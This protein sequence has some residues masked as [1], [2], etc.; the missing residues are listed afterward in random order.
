MVESVVTLTML[1]YPRTSDFEGL[2]YISTLYQN[3]FAVCYMSIKMCTNAPIY[4]PIHRY[5]TC[6]TVNLCAGV[7]AQH[8]KEMLHY[9]NT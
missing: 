8:L 1:S 4:E 9:L 5:C 7:M 6:R 2:V 3:A